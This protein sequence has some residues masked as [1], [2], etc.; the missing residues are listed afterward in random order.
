MFRG[1]LLEAMTRLDSL[2]TFIND[3]V[4]ASL[5]RPF[6]EVVFLDWPKIAVNLEVVSLFSIVLLITR[7]I[8]NKQIFGLQNT[9][10]IYIMKFEITLNQLN[11]LVRRC[12]PPME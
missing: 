3:R 9:K 8:L 4:E 11:V 1:A 10:I 12:V 2:S 6:I 5:R 7:K